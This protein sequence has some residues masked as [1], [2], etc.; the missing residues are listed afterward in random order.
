MREPRLEAGGRTDGRSQLNKYTTSYEVNTSLHATLWCWPSSLPFHC[1]AA[2]MAVV[3]LTRPSTL[4]P[5]RQ[6][7]TSLQMS[8]MEGKFRLWSVSM[9]SST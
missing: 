8:Q 5:A 2:L 1:A 6:I 4:L 3:T 9:H 7:H